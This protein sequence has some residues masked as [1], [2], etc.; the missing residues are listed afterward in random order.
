[1]LSV[2]AFVVVCDMLPITRAG[3]RIIRSVD[4][5]LQGITCFRVRLSRSTMLRRWWRVGVRKSCY[6]IFDLATRHTQ[7]SLG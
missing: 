1:M 6:L 4:S 7:V 5:F 3:Y 2:T